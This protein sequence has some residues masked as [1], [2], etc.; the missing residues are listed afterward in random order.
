MDRSYYEDKTILELR[1]MLRDRGESTSGSKAELVDRLVDLDE[2]Q[3]VDLGPVEVDSHVDVV[4]EAVDDVAEVDETAAE[5]AVAEA[6]GYVSAVPVPAPSEADLLETCSVHGVLLVAG[7]C[8]VGGHDSTGWTPI[9]QP[10]VQVVSDRD[11][12]FLPDETR[13]PASLED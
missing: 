12:T 6:G 5:V 1:D 8:P 7:R 3:T 2:P 9:E 13:G 11:D 10:V 4:D